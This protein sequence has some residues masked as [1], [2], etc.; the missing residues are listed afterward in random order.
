MKKL[1]FALIFITAA[2][3]AQVSAQTVA[4]TNVN[5]I[6]LDRERVIANQTVVV[7]NGLIA[8]IAVAKKVKLPKDAVQIDGSG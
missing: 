7:K 2:L 6:P 3:A 8:E 5:V 4:F 1:F